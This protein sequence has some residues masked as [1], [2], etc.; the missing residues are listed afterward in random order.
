MSSPDLLDRAIAIAVKA[1]SGQKDRNGAPYILH[2]LRVMNRVDTDLEK[3]IAVLHDV[4][5]DTGWSLETLRAEGFPH[6]VITAVDC[7]TKRKSETY[8]ALIMRAA[9]NRLALKVKVADLEDNMDVRRTRAITSEFA[10]RLD[11]YSRAWH[12]LKRKLE[13]IG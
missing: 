9:D 10:Q 2:P 6:E 1:H 4:V 13:A 11:R 5:E 8:E 12:E 3:I 7:L